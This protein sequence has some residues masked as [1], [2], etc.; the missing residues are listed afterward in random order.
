MFFQRLSIVI[1][2]FIL[3]AEASKISNM[4][5][6]VYYFSGRADEIKKIER[7]LKKEN[8][9]S[10]VGVSGVGKTEL[11]RRYAEMQKNNYEIIWV[12]EINSDLSVQFQQL[13]RRINA[14][15]GNNKVVVSEDLNNCIDSVLFFLKNKK[16]WLIIFDN[17]KVGENIK[18]LDFIQRG[19]NG[20]FMIISQDKQDLKNLIDIDF[21]DFQNSRKII[22]KINTNIS[23]VQVNEFFKKFQGYP[24]PLVQA[25]YFTKDNSNLF[26]PSFEESSQKSFNAMIRSIIKTL[27]RSELN[28]L[29]KAA[30]LNNHLLTP[31]I[32]LRISY[33]KN[34]LFALNR[35]NFIIEKQNKSLRYFEM[36]DLIKN[37][38]LSIL[39]K[40]LIKENVEELVDQANSIWPRSE[41][42]YPE[43][44]DK[45]PNIIDN[46]EHLLENAE[47]QEI[48]IYKILELHKNLLN[49][50]FSSLNYKPVKRHLDWFLNNKKKLLM[51]NLD[52][53]RKAAI[54]TMLFQMGAYKNFIEDKPQDA[55][56]AFDESISII[57]GASTPEVKF[58]VY[59]QYAETLICIGNIEDAHKNIKIAQEISLSNPSKMDEA[60]LNFALSNIFLEKGEY[61]V[62]L[63]Y[64]LKSK[65]KVTLK[66]MY[67]GSIYE[68]EAITLLRQGEWQ[69]AYDISKK[70][71]ELANKSFDTD[72]D[73]KNR[74]LIFLAWSEARLGHLKEAEEH[75]KVAKKFFLKQKTDTERSGGEYLA[76]IN[77]VQGDIFVNMHKYR[78]AMESYIEAEINLKKIY[79]ELKN[80]FYGFILERIVEAAS[81]GKM[82]VHK[83]QYIFEYKKVF[84]EPDK[85]LERMENLS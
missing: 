82:N 23:E 31:E 2:L 42:L 13:A 44:L 81:L 73:L 64:I 18:I 83:I 62:A 72:H 43:V 66:N 76:Y 17:L 19:S 51:G 55:K 8:I 47:K 33:S 40:G 70:Y 29:I 12:F 21:L 69:K 53:S 5:S 22:K 7:T 14:V 58:N 61:E 16:Q 63:K 4:T 32:M 60:A 45:Y 79:M 48:N 9:V 35:I 34:D 49:A 27:K 38:L 37:N 56:Q 25:A 15:Y 26:L 39:D 78:E 6:P 41:H 52:D 50:H 24:L 3:D 77:I 80:D 30:N 59:E 71:L 10:I 75:I 68:L 11:S 74:A 57:N 65:E 84:K 36:H 46:L 85:R 54:A 20:K 1:F 28:L 67:L